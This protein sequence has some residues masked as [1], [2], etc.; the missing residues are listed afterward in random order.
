MFLFVSHVCF[1]QTG[2]RKAALLVTLL[3]LSLIAHAASS[4]AAEEPVNNVQ[5]AVQTQHDQM[6]HGRGQSFNFPHWP[7]HH[8]VNQQ[9]TNKEIIPP[10]PPGPYMS[11][12]LSDYSVRA[13]SFG[14]YPGKLEQHNPAHRNDS[15]SVPM[16]MF[17]PDIPW[18]KNLRP[19]QYGTPNRW[20]PETDYY[21][22][23]PQSAQKSFSV[24]PYGPPA[25][26][27]YKNYYG[28][29]YS[30]YMNGSR[31]MPSM[32]MVPQGPYGNG[33]NHAPNYGSNYDPRYDRPVMNNY[34]TKSANP[35]YPQSSRPRYP[36]QGW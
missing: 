19:G 26:N 32:G 8:Q 34:G 30:P 10:P 33:L 20:M 24:P 31:R 7:Q 23:P 1:K 13:P 28:N 36:N 2:V 14:S 25:N 3:T 6:Q 15:T 21:Y 12:A 5:Q 35:P 17:S 9:Q 4:G 16:D 18:P 11:S 22:A 29:R 27:Q